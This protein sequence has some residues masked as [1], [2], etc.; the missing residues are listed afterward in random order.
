MITPEDVR[1]A[2]LYDLNSTLLFGRAAEARQLAMRVGGEAELTAISL[3][4]WRLLASSLRL[5]EDWVLY[6]LGTMATE[7][8]GVIADL[9][10]AP[11]LSGTADRTL[12]RF[13]D[14]ADRWCTQVRK[15]F[16]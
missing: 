7:L 6:Q 14:R 2:P 16:S 11:D 5:D 4:N 3:G 13:R 10:R 12:Q 1:L 9:T 8:P 15:V